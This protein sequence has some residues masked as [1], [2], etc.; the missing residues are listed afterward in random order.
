[1]NDP[2]AFAI[3]MDA[4]EKRFGDFQA[5]N[6]LSLAVKPGEIYGLLGPN[7]AG[8]TTALRMLAGLLTP[9]AGRA[10]VGSIDV[11]REPEEAR[12]RLGFLTGSAGLYARLTAREVLEYTA[13]LHGLSRH[14]A[15]RRIDDLTAA[16]SLAPMLEIRCETLSTGQK[17]RVSLARA[18]IHDPVALVLDEPTAGLDVMASHGLRLF[19]QAERARGKAILMSTHYLAEAELMCDR[20]GFM[21]EGRLIR[22]DR[23]EAVRAQENAS[24]LEEAFLKAVGVMATAAPPVGA[25]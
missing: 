19:V 10:M 14:D 18:V 3:V 2:P 20:V 16:L 15:H 23:P 6:G 4:L 7:G 5:V 11:A 24:S 8:K 21:H 13:A 9:T 12:R 22:E 17:Q 1:V 25:T